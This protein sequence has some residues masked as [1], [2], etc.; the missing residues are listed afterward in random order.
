MGRIRA[1]LGGFDQ[2]CAAPDPGSIAQ[3]ISVFDAFPALQPAAGSV[4]PT[5]QLAVPRRACRLNCAFLDANI[6]P[7]IV[8]AEALANPQG[9]CPVF[10]QSHI[11]G[12]TLGESSVFT[13]VAEGDC[14][15]MAGV[16]GL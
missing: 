1:T 5:T 3:A 4:R 7:H 6:G 11:S 8:I 10:W 9:H 14:K 12:N 16:G 15:S 2:L 13:R